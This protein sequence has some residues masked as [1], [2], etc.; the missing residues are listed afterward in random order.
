MDGVLSV[1]PGT[2]ERSSSSLPVQVLQSRP[3]SV[4]G[5]RGRVVMARA[6]H[7]VEAVGWL[8]ECSRP[9]LERIFR[10]LGRGGIGRIEEA[11]ERE[12]LGLAAGGTAFRYS[13]ARS[14]HARNH[15]RWMTPQPANPE[16][17]TI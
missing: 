9:A 1:T 3:V 6:R 16:T 17:T 14:R 7:G 13:S 5:M 2:A 11:L 10:G 12:G 4:L 8:I 15:E